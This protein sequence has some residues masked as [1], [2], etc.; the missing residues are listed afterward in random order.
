MPPSPKSCSDTETPSL[1]QA[2]YLYWLQGTRCSG[3]SKAFKRRGKALRGQW[4]FPSTCHRAWQGLGIRHLFGFSWVPRLELSPP[5]VCHPSYFF[6]GLSLGF[7]SFFGLSLGFLS[8]FGLS[9]GGFFHLD[10]KAPLAPPTVPRPDV[11]PIWAPTEKPAAPAKTDHDVKSQEHRGCLL[12]DPALG[13]DGQGLLLGR[14]N[15]ESLEQFRP[16]KS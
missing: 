10:S 9:L 4:G 5:H 12:R 13:T 16:V 15:L 7:L 1:L 6:L 2:K 3:E 11:S 14:E 8:S